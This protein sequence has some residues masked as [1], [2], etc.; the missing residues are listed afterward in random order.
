M[1]KQDLSLNDTDF[2]RKFNN[3][4]NRLSKN[5]TDR[6]VI[7]FWL[8]VIFASTFIL[9]AG[10]SWMLAVIGIIFSFI[11]L[12]IGART[13]FYGRIFLQEAVLF[14]LISLI[15]L[16]FYSIVF[17]SIL[18]L[19]SNLIFVNWTNAILSSKLA[20]INDLV[21]S[22]ASVSNN[23]S[24]LVG[25]IMVANIFLNFGY[26]FYYKYCITS[27]W[28]NTIYKAT[29]PTTSQEYQALNDEA[30]V[31]D[32]F[33]NKYLKRMLILKNTRN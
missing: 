1:H 22:N 26:S 16:L 10:Y 28:Y 20:F 4:A 7:M 24:I 8:A 31:N 27:F 17:I 9:V 19:S 18:A 14:L 30:I 33:G 11:A 15:P 32:Y 3:Y 5:S 23:M 29:L 13:L 2:I 21:F 6:L 12:M 25:F